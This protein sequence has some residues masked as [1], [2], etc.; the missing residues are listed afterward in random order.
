MTVS[1]LTCDD[2]NTISGDGCSSTCLVESQYRCENGS[3]TT[4]SQCVYLGVSL[5]LNVSSI[6]RVE[7]ENRANLAFSIWPAL[8][9]LNK[10][11]FSQCA[12]LSCN[13]TFEMSSISYAS[14]ILTI[15][16]NYSEDFEDKDCTLSISYN[17]ELIQDT[18]SSLNF[19][20]KSDGTPLL[21]S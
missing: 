14:G 4:A 12:S 16:T 15:V 1:P 7:G 18:N 6:N 11:D 2:G 8:I 10:L 19:T 17:S 3:S 13:T 21:Y 20:V 9:V 5:A